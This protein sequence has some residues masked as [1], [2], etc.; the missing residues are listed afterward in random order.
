MD[1]FQ[2]TL[3]GDELSGPA[4]VNLVT[5]TSCCCLV[6]ETILTPH[7][8]SQALMFQKLWLVFIQAR[9]TNNTPHKTPQ[10]VK[11]L[12]HKGPTH[13]DVLL[14]S[15]ITKVFITV[16]RTEYVEKHLISFPLSMI[17]SPIFSQQN[18]LLSPAHEMADWAYMHVVIG[19]REAGESW[20]SDRP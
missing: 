7:F 8:L 10:A 15:L 17:P 4:D 3:R 9:A 13:S 5:K 19:K 1:H 11:V 18:F 6:T 2:Q 14:P 12:I 16:L 20:F